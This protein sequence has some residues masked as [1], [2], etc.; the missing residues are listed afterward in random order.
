MQDELG[1]KQF[2]ITPGH[3]CSY[4]A[5]RQARTLFLDPRE[6]I[7]PRTYQLLTEQGFRRSGAHLYRPH[8]RTCQACVPTRIPVAT[9]EPRRSQRRALRR[10]AD[11]TVQVHRAAFS[12]RFYDLYARYIGGRHADGDMF[13]PS[14]DQFRSF[15]LSHWADTQ[16]LCSYLHERLVAVAVTDRQAAGLSAIYTFFDPELPERSLGVWSV[17]QQIEL[18]R[19]LQLP[20]VYLGYWIRDAEKMRYKIDYRPVELFLNGRWV[21]VD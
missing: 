3:A 13:P 17:L 8:C 21:A 18:A 15:L 19:R 14:R 16:F 1:N 12:P 5:R 11:L 10:N 9:F 4:L 20:Y 6:T 2:F 7:T